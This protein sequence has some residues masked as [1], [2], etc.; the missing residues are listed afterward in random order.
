VTCAKAESA[1]WVASIDGS[2]VSTD[3]QLVGEADSA[4]EP[5][6]ACGTAGSIANAEAATSQTPSVNKPEIDCFAQQK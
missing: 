4:V 5:A 2:A 3:S 6:S 1:V